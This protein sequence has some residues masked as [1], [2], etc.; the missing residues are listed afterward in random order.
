VLHELNHAGVDELRP[1]AGGSGGSGGA[2][3]PVASEPDLSPIPGLL[4][5]R[6]G[7]PL[8]TANARGVQAKILDRVAATDPRPRVLVLDGTAVGALSATTLTVFRELDRQ[9]ADQGIELWLAAL[10]PRALAQARQLPAWDGLD[11]AGRLHPTAREAVAA[12]AHTV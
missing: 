12:F 9:L 7:A 11:A 8:Y 3:L 2:L 10:P 6:I 5:L 1:R 4:V